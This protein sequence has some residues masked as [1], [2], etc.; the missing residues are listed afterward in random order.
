MK[1][2]GICFTVT[3]RW[4]RFYVFSLPT[5]VGIPPF[6]PF[7]IQV[8]FHIQVMDLYIHFVHPPRPQGR[9]KMYI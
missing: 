7:S 9:D 2:H 1:I 5:T 6:I 3:V 4:D 8:D